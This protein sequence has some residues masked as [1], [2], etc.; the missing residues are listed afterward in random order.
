MGFWVRLCIFNFLK[1]KQ[2]FFFHL[3][4]FFFVFLSQFYHSF[5]LSISIIVL[6]KLKFVVQFFKIHFVAF[7][8]SFYW[9]NKCV[10][11]TTS[12]ITFFKHLV[13]Y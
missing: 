5:N 11:C 7:F 1:L 8:A 9:K 13:D 10:F 12:T 2:I 6:V 3:F 4:Q